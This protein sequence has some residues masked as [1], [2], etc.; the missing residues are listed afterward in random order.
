MPR[1]KPVQVESRLWLEVGGGFYA[2]E[3][4]DPASW[5][6]P[7]WRLT[8]SEGDHYEVHVASH[9]PSCTCPD[10]IWCREHQD[11][12]GCKHVV[13]LRQQGLLRRKT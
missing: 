9:G 10:F 8:K 4:L 1:R 6:E 2:L 7:A 11:P 12:A 5:A 3:Y 13:A